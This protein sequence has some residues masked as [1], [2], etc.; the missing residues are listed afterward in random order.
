M[1]NSKSRSGLLLLIVA[2]AISLLTMPVHRLWG[3]LMLFLAIMVTGSIFLAAGLT[4]ERRANAK[5]ER[6]E[7]VHSQS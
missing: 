7:E 2:A 4:E 3:I 6:A 5:L 1:A